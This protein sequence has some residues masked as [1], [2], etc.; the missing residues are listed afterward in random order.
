MDKFVS[1]AIDGPSASGK[2]TVAKILAS[3]VNFTYIDTGAMYR[4]FT[5]AVIKNG[6]DPKNETESD[7][8]IG[9]I[10]ISFDSNNKIC[11]NGEDVSKE[12]RDNEVA[13]NVS[14]IASYKN[15]RLFLVDLQRKIAKGRNVVM[16]GRDIGTYVLQ[17]AQLKI[18]L[19]ADVN[20]RGKRRFLENQSKNI[21][22]S[23][24]DSL[25]NIKKRDYI[26]SHRDFCPLTPASDS[27]NID[28]T[29]ISAEEV[30]TKILDLAKERGLI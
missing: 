30:A 22:S 6:L 28:S 25:A 9:K 5:L 14:Y 3:K 29:N 23:F 10:D 12:I 7:S 24:D 8:L 17:D 2:S 11:L 27:I 15:I 21:E 16:D 19:V 1:I 18:F 20:E 4:A 26:D 13:D